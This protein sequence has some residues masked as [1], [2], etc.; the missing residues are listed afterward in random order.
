MCA[1]T[2]SSCSTPDRTLLPQSVLTNVVRPWRHWLVEKIDGRGLLT[3]LT[4]AGCTADHDAKLD[5]LLDILLAP[6]LW[7]CQWPPLDTSE[8]A[9]LSWERTYVGRHCV[10]RVDGSAATG[11]RQATTMNECGGG[12]VVEWEMQLLSGLLLVQ[13]MGEVQPGGDPSRTG[14]NPRTSSRQ[15]HGAYNIYYRVTICLA[16]TATHLCLNILVSYCFFCLS[17]FSSRPRLV[18]RSSLLLFS[19]C[20]RSS[21]EAATHAFWPLVSCLPSSRSRDSSISPMWPLN[22]PSSSSIRASCSSRL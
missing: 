8:T 19:T 20:P 1:L 10:L 12:D 2:G 3:E 14:P 9:T 7:L 18:Y 21:E 15:D 13:G 11:W 22:V 5:T 6:N 16:I 4:S 17:C